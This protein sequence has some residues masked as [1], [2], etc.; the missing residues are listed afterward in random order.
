MRFQGRKIRANGG[1]WIEIETDE[2]PA[3]LRGYDAALIEYESI[4]EAR[5][6]KR[7]EIRSGLVRDCETLMPTYELIYCI[8]QRIADTRL[9]ELDAMAKRA[10]DLEAYIDA[11]T[12][13][14]AEV[15]AVNWS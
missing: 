8:R 3:T 6:E 12:R 14:V 5:E 11:S 13:T 15:E 4:E 7:A 10:R 2:G 1:D 9:S